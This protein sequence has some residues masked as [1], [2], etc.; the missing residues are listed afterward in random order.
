MRGPL[1]P[2]ALPMSRTRAEAFDD[3]VLDAVE[4]LERRW[5]TQLEHVQFAVEDV[6]PVALL[7]S[8]AGEPVPLGSC[9]ASTATAPAQ[10]VVYRRPIE[11]RATGTEE[12]ADLVHDVVVEEVAELLG[13]EPEA[14]DPGYGE[15][16]DDDSDDDS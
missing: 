16:W 3:L 14:V 8:V 2:S 7:G 1:A 5:A 6:P 11:A 9:S 4:H 10:V 15:G 12:L 13:L